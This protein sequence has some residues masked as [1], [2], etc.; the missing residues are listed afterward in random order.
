MAES[1]T[2][3]EALALHK[4][5][6]EDVLRMPGG[7]KITIRRRCGTGS[8]PASHLMGWGSREIIVAVRAG[9]ITAE[10]AA[11]ANAV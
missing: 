9:T 7:A 5:F 10:L 1:A 8:C 6:G 3:P 11:G 4:Q 2:S